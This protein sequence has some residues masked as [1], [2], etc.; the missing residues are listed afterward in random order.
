MQSKEEGGSLCW[1]GCSCECWPDRRAVCIRLAPPSSHKLARL[2]AEMLGVSS[3]KQRGIR[4]PLSARLLHRLPARQAS[5]VYPPRTAKQPQ[6]RLLLRVLARQPCKQFAV[7]YEH[8]AR[9]STPPPT[10][11]SEDEQYHLPLLTSA[12]RMLR[13]RR[14]LRPRREV[15]SRGHC[16]PQT[17]G[18]RLV[19]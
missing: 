11:P 7:P 19:G 18:L 4:Q 16:L 14:S 10:T 8:P 1:Q 9:P 3:A 2:V 15:H 12:R 17:S 5:S 13:S 6:A